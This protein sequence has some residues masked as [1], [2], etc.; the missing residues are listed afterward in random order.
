MSDPATQQTIISA[1]V[2]LVV[3]VALPLLRVFAPKT[4][5]TI[6]DAILKAMEHRLAYLEGLIDRPA[7][8]APIDISVS[9]KGKLDAS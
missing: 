7:L 3:S 4:K 1:L 6:D 8:S 5:N 9:T 2:A